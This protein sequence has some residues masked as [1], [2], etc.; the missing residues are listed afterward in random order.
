MEN[1]FN[2]SVRVTNPGS[3][4]KKQIADYQSNGFIHI[5]NV[6]S[7]GEIDLYLEEAKR[8]FHEKKKVSWE[9]N[10]GNV[11]EWVSDVETQGGLMRKLVLHPGI[12]GIAVKLASKELRVLKSELLLKRESGSTITPMHIDDF[13]FPLMNAPDTLTVWVALVDVPVDKGCMTFIPGSHRVVR[14]GIERMGNEWKEQGKVM[15][16][17]FANDPLELFP[18]LSWWPRVTVP[19]RAGDCT[20]HHSQT[21][22]MAGANLTKSPRVSLATVYTNENALYKAEDPS[23]G[24]GENYDEYQPKAFS[25]LEDGAPLPEDLFPKVGTKRY[26]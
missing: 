22:H 26:I 20:I 15:V 21:L 18:A 5:P 12:T 13:A 16:D 14:D 4:S 8:L 11:M 7:R 25:A 24:G 17:L 19:L 2:N 1:S 10:E 3:I 23:G 6:L 9:E